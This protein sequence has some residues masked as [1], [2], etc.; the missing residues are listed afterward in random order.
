MLVKTN[1]RV[2]SKEV[3]YFEVPQSRKVIQVPEVSSNAYP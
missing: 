3:A 1:F 2:T